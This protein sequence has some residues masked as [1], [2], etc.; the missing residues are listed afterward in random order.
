MTEHLWFTTARLTIL[1]PK[2][3]NADGIS[4][5][6]HRMARDFAVP[7][8]LHR[9]EAESFCMLEGR[10]LLRMG[11]AERTLQPGEA[12]SVPDGMPHAFRVLSDEARF[13]TMT[14]GPFEDMVRSLSRPAASPGLPPQEAPTPQQVA[15]LVAACAAHGIE[16][17]EPDGA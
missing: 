13:L 10:V 11:D 8:H 9:D 4:L 2:R 16:F 6:E 7:L 14:T 1:L 17:L 12:V 5:I 3:D 15:A